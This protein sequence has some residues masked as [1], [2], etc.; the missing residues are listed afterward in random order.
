MAG[1]GV[2]YT[3]LSV[4]ELWEARQEKL[5]S[6]SPIMLLLA[7]HAVAIPVRIPSSPR[8]PAQPSMSTC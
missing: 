6:R 4:F 5:A 3:L 8:G 2:A 7:A 1:I